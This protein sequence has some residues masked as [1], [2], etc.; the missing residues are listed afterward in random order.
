MYIPLRCIC[1]VA[2]YVVTRGGSY[3]TIRR[4]V[5]RKMWLL[6]KQYKSASRDGGDD[7][8]FLLTT[9]TPAVAAVT[10]PVGALHP[11]RIVSITVA[12]LC[13]IWPYARSVWY[14][15]LSRNGNAVPQ[16]LSNCVRF[17][18]LKDVNKSLQHVSER[19]SEH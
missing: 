3:V 5:D 18:K 11:I 17:R 7:T 14:H 2:P 19:C 8:C 15:C 9:T 16:A 12:K 1:R 4:A 6:Q 13:H 10:S